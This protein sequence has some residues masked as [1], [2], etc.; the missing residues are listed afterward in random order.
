MSGDYQPLSRTLM[1][2][3]LSGHVAHHASQW[4][5]PRRNFRSKPMLSKHVKQLG[6]LLP[7]V[8]ELPSTIQDIEAD[9]K[10]LPVLIKQ[11]LKVGGQL[12]GSNVDPRFSNAL[13][14]LV[15]MDLRTAFG[16]M[17]D[18]C[19]GRTGAARFRAWHA[20]N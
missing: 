17:L 10:G 6:R 12:L 5:R 9:G 4:I 14:V 20:L 19:L 18:R 15:M 2:N 7:S 1:M 11:Y 13:D 3:F 8:E 16:P